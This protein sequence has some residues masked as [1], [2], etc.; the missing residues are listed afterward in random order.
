MPA[1]QRD[2]VTS[3]A[4]AARSVASLVLNARFKLY[5]LLQ[6]QPGQGD[7][8]QRVTDIVWQLQLACEQNPDVALAVILHAQEGKYSIRHSVDTALVVDLVCERLDMNPLDRQSVV[9]A[10]LTMNL[11]MIALQEALSEQSTPL[12]SAQR[13]EMHRHPLVG[14]EMLRKLGVSDQLWLDCVLQH[15]EMPDGGGYPARLQGEELRFEARLIGLADRY[16]AMLTQAAWRSGSVVDSALFRTLRAHGSAADAKLGRLFGDTLGLFPPGAVVRLANGESGVVKQYAN[17]AAPLVTALFDD[18]DMP[19]L[20]PVDRDTSKPQFAITEMLEPESL[21]GR[22]QFEQV[23]GA[24]AA[25][26]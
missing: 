26:L 14:R 8:T 15:H 11:G 13:E 24:A 22:V 21:I 16:C 7:F 17:E 12:T 10:A 20:E 18:A 19:L 25:G 9:S 2:T 1:A 6:L 4:S 3:S 23:W 5:D